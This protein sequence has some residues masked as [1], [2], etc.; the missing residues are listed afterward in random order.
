MSDDNDH[1]QAQDGFDFIE[2]PCEY[3]FKAMC[4]VTEGVDLKQ[5][6]SELVANKINLQALLSVRSNSSR[7]G[8]FESITLTVKLN[9]REQL[10][11][12]YQ[13]I[14]ASPFVVM[15]L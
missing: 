4:K 2:Y 8:K 7:T 11:S 14:A 1:S 12:V 15:T 13:A 9:N 3:G 10:E 6:L 5:L